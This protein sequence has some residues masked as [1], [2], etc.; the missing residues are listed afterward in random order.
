MGTVDSPFY[1]TGLG[2]PAYPGYSPS[3]LHPGG[4]AGTPFAP[5]N[6]VTPFAP[7]VSQTH[8]HYIVA[9][10]EMNHSLSFIIIICIHSLVPCDIE[11]EKLKDFFFF[12]I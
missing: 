7:K 12:N 8:K 2:V 4:L 3:L 5:P 10:H 1:R 6:H 9:L 11:L